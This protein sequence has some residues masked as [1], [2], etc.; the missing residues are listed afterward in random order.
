MNTLTNPSN[1]VHKTV[2]NPFKDAEQPLDVGK[3]S[4]LRLRAWAIDR[5]RTD[6]E[7]TC[8]SEAYRAEVYWDGYIRAIEHILEME[9]E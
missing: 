2:R 1:V 6:R 8:R 3:N 7:S 9:D 5:L 4:V